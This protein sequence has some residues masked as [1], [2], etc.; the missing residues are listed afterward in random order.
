[1]LIYAD[2][3]KDQRFLASCFGFKKLTHLQKFNVG[4]CLV[5]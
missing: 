3:S 5:V 4:I 2:K 1:M